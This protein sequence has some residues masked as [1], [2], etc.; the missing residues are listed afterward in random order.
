MESEGAGGPAETHLVGWF[1]FGSDRTRLVGCLRYRSC[2]QRPAG[3]AAGR[4]RNK[5]SFKVLGG[6]S[7]TACSSGT[8]G[9]RED[10]VEAEIEEWEEEEVGRRAR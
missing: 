1:S 8:R 7:E 10:R 5:A 6:V 2:S 4:R 9:V 3:T